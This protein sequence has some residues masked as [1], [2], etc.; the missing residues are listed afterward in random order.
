[1]GTASWYPLASTTTHWPSRNLLNLIFKVPSAK[2]HK[3]S[4]LINFSSSP[5]TL[6]ACWPSVLHSCP[7]QGL[8]NCASLCQNAPP[9]N[10]FPLACFHARRPYWSNTTH[11]SPA[12]LDYCLQTNITII[13]ALTV[14]PIPHALFTMWP[15]PSCHQMV[16]SVSPFPDAECTFLTALNIGHGKSDAV[17]LPKLD[18]KMPWTLSGYSLKT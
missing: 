13:V 3:W 7:R 12:D 5:F 17:W 14:S 10:L 16:A 1:M 6:Q 9:L 18:H 11:F 2:L 15:G 4:L 8:C